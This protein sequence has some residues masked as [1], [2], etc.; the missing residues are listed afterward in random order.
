M[1][2]LLYFI[3]IIRI[4]LKQLAHIEP[5][6]LIQSRVA[7]EFHGS[8]YG[9][10]CIPK[11]IITARSVVVDVGLGED[12]S[13][14]CSLIDRYNCSIHGFDPTPRAITYIESRAPRKFHLYRFALATYD[15]VSTFHLP[16]NEEHV[17]GS[18]DELD[19]TGLRKIEVEVVNLAGVLGKV[20]ANHIDLLKLDI[21]GAEYEILFDNRF[22]EYAHRISVLCIEFHHRWPAY[23]A[24]KTRMACKRLNELGFICVW[25]NWATNEEFTFMRLTPNLE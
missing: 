6:I 24:I 23:G 17:S 8:E 4:K 21:E 9:G 19:H 18:L 7:L 3:R 14:S 10:W 5:V 13:F 12:I 15:G 1:S 16:T 20:G 22:A 25:S 11:N 2:R